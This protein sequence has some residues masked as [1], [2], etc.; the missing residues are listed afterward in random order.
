[1]WTLIHI[2]ITYYQQQIKPSFVNYFIKRLTLYLLQ[3][4]ISFATKR[5]VWKNL[6]TPTFLWWEQIWQCCCQ[7]WPQCSKWV[8]SWLESQE[9]G[10]QEPVYLINQYGI[11]SFN[12]V[13]PQPTIIYCLIYIVHIVYIERLPDKLLFQ[14]RLQHWTSFLITIICIKWI[15]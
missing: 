1:M 8:L 4:V 5:I 11:Y 13:N 14:F 15:F 12:L 2:L 10:S 6:A 3:I 9:P 7:D